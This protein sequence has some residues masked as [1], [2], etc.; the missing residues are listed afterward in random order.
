MAVDVTMRLSRSSESNLC[1]PI[2]VQAS[3]C[4]KTEAAILAHELLDAEQDYGQTALDNVS[5]L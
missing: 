4:Y 1:H 5:V 2:A 3:V